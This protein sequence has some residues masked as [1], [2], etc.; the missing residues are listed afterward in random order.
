MYRNRQPIVL[1]SSSPRRRQFLQELGLDFAV[2]TG[3]VAEQPMEGEKP[4]DFVLRMADEKAAEV[5]GQYP[6]AW[7]I[8]GDTVVCLD[9][10]ILGKP[11]DEEE[12]VAL[13]M[14]LSGR[15]HRVMTGFCVAH[16]GR[17]IK[18]VE[19]VTTYVRF[20]RFSEQVA[21]AYAATG[22]CLDKAGAYGIQ[23]IGGCLVESI[24]G[25]YSNVV[26]L[27]LSQL[28]QALL[29]HGVIE[30]A[31]PETGKGPR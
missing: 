16:A 5:S 31:S 17:G 2:R 6:E 20:I 24:D 1:A 12:A 26:G 15:E 30:P 13:L 4:E 9:R 21:R 23:G 28:L 7:V 8:A 29:A 18:I 10:K 14:A 3:T 11:A 27:P 25:S 22:E 19:S